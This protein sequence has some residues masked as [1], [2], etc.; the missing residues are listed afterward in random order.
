MIS[1]EEQVQ[2]YLKQK[3]R[4]RQRAKAYYEK[5]RDRVKPQMRDH[6]RCKKAKRDGSMLELKEAVAGMRS[7]VETFVAALSALDLA[8]RAPLPLQKISHPENTQGE[9]WY[10]QPSSL[11]R[12]G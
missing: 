8:L 12:I 2:L 9:K 4:A 7:A 5:H 6:A 10:T 1:I 3:E 11:G